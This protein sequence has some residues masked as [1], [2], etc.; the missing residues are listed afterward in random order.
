MISNIAET[1]CTVSL[2]LWIVSFIINFPYAAGHR[3]PQ[4]KDVNYSVKCLT[5]G[6]KLSLVEG[7][8]KEACW[9]MMFWLANP[10]CHYPA[11]Y[12]LQTASRFSFW[13]CG[14][15]PFNSYGL[16]HPLG[17]SRV[18]FGFIKL[19]GCCFNLTNSFCNAVDLSCCS[20]R[21]WVFL[22]A[23]LLFLSVS[24]VKADIHIF[25]NV[26]VSSLEK[27]KLVK[28]NVLK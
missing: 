13:C 11:H 1:Q 25:T 15:M 26:E 5:A 27:K 28:E 9:V 10:V 19:L 16:P 21:A 8:K 20:Q 23:A 14:F 6:L 3:F 2:D 18:L 7:G 12:F 24:L 22:P 4:I 17:V